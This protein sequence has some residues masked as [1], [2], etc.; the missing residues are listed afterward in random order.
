MYVGWLAVVW[1]I[2]GRWVAA[3]DTVEVT[4]VLESLSVVAFPRNLLLSQ[5]LL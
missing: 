5:I 3:V 2:K 1:P 4:H